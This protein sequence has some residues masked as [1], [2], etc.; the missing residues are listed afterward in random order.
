MNEGRP[1]YDEL[2]ALIQKYISTNYPNLF[3]H[4]REEVLNRIKTYSRA[5]CSDHGILLDDT[6]LVKIQQD[7][8]EFDCFS[9]Y[10]S[11]PEVEEVNVNCWNDA[12]ATYADGRIISIP[13]TFREPQETKQIIDRMLRVSQKVLDNSSPILRTHL[14]P[15][16]RISAIN[17]NNLM[18]GDGV[19]A[20]IRIVNPKM[21]DKNDFI[22]N[23]TATGE[24]LD[25]L[26]TV[27][28][29]G[30]SICCAGSTG[31][32]K[33]TL[34][35]WLLSQMPDEK[36]IFTIEEGVQEFNLRKYDKNGNAINNVVQTV[37][38]ESDEHRYEVT[39][40]D[41]LVQGLT[42]NPDYI[43]ISE[44]K[45]VDAAK[46]TIEAANTGH[47]LITTVHANSCDSIYYRFMYLCVDGSIDSS[48][49]Y[50]MAIEAFPITLFTKKLEDNSRRI[51]EI[52]ET[53]VLP[54]GKKIVKTLYRFNVTK[55]GLDVGGKKYVEGYFE[56]VNAISENLQ[57]KLKANGIPTKELDKLLKGGK[58]HDTADNNYVSL[59]GVRRLAAL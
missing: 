11:D 28:R 18:Q 12:K 58:N 1:P 35:A 42:F 36:R 5:Y 29:Y 59:D 33:T 8:V 34:I 15:K 57:A 23:G 2:F 43:M 25:F 27:Y 53:V 49:L 9:P 6:T 37:T 30:A 48:L 32:G 4:S 3:Q 38:M 13:M 17:G 47:S 44:T 14:G 54:D 31:S 56:K 20:S 51:M 21:L 19:A 22:A 45:S 41:L 40:E 24:M 46:K 39:M 55:N 7:M 10:L 26:T 50:A 16:K 52:A